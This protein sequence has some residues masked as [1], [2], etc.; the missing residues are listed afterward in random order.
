[1][2]NTSVNY[3]CPDC[4]KSGALWTAKCLGCAARKIAYVR[5]PDSKLSIS[6]QKAILSGFDEHQKQEI[7]DK[8]KQLD[9]CA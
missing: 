3:K 2:R 4:G 6:M 8:L 1:M 9:A 7:L 5:S